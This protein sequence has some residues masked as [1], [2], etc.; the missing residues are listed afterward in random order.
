MNTR[1][2]KK[3]GCLKV[4]GIVFGVLIL[5]VI[6]A[7]LL[8]KDTGTQYSSASSTNP[9]STSSVASPKAS[10]SIVVEATSTPKPEKT[11]VVVGDIAELEGIAIQVT[12]VEIS[13]GTTIDKPKTGMEFVI[14]HVFVKN[15]GDTVI[16]Y[17]PYYFKMQNSQGQILD[18]TIMFSGSEE[19]LSSGELIPGG[20]VSGVIPYEQP[21]DD[22]GLI[23]IYND[24]ALFSDKQIS[25]RLSESL[26]TITPMTQTKVAITNEQVVAVG[27]ENLLDGTSVTV[28]KVTRSADSESSK[29]AVGKEFIIITLE[30]ENTGTSTL[31]YNPFDFK[32]RNGSGQMESQGFAGYV[33]SKALGSGDLVKGGKVSGDLIFEE[34]KDDPDLMLIYTPNMFI[35]KYMAFK[36]K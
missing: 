5:L 33:S 20:I 30:I 8:N 26:P 35:D 12:K 18:A 3:G 6:I 13:K 25:I 16:S 34:I 17:N 23:F 11:D 10:E 14:V 7:N 19:E 21:V 1:P 28:T 31:S 9:K 27:N 32:M 36:L 24:I 15:V 2:K 4:I 22:K 29:P